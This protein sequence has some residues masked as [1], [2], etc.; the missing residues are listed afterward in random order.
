MLPAIT[1]FSF[2]GRS[3]AGRHVRAL[4]RAL[5][6][7]ALTMLV[8]CGGGSDEPPPPPAQPDNWVSRNWEMSVHHPDGST[9]VVVPNTSSG[10]RP[11]NLQHSFGP[12]A[13]APPG[14][15]FEAIGEVFSNA[16]GDTYWV[17][18]QAPMGDVRVPQSPIGSSVYYNQFQ[19]FRKT[20]DA[21]D[22]DLVISESTLEAMDYNPFNPAN[23]RGCSRETHPDPEGVDITTYEC[24]NLIDAKLTYEVFAW[25]EIPIKDANGNVTGSSQV[26]LTH[27]SVFSH[28]YGYIKGKLSLYPA[29]HFNSGPAGDGNLLFDQQPDFVYSDNVDFNAD[30]THARAFLRQ[31]TVIHI[32]LDLVNRD[33]EFRVVVAVTADTNN[34]RQRES[35]AG[36]FLRDP[37]KLSGVTYRSNGVAPVTVAAGTVGVAGTPPAP[38]PVQAAPACATGVDPAAGVLQFDSDSTVATEASV[39]GMV[40]VWVTRSGGGVGALTVRVATQDDSAHAGADYQAV[41][42]LVRFADGE[43]GQRYVA[44]PLINNSLV[45][46]DRRLTLTLSELR[47]CAVLGP[48]ASTV[49]T[50][51]DDETPPPP[52]SFTLGGTVTGL[53]GSGLSLRNTNGGETV[54]PVADGSFTFASPLA[55]G[56]A[57]AVSVTTQPANPAQTCTVTNGS[58]TVPGANVT[59]IVVA[60][61]SPAPNSSLDAGFGSAG[62]LSNTLPAAKA[63]ALQADGK[64][65]LLGGMTLSRYNADGSTDAGFGTAGRV[66][67]VANGGGL[68]AMQALAVQADGRVVVAGYTALPVVFNQDMVVLRYNADGSLDTTFGSGGKVVTDFTGSTDRA[69][70]VLVQADGKIVAAGIATLGSGTSADQDL[71]LVRYLANGALDTGFGVG[72]KVTTN[73]AGTADFGYAAAL[74]P[75]GKIVVAGRV[76]ANG[77]ANPDFGLARYLPNGTLDA[78]FGSSGIVRIDF[79]GNV[80]D[81]ASDLAVQGDGKIVVGGQAAFGSSYRFAL[82]RLN[83]NGTLDTGFGTAG[84]VRT[85]F[86]TRNDYGRGLALQADG[87]IVLAGQVSGSL[88]ADFGVARYLSSG[89]VDTGFG[90]AGLVQVDFFGATDGAMDVVVQPDGK[91]VAAGSA[92]NGLATGLAIVRVLP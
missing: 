68:D 45:D 86:S 46:P 66:T 56:L 55:D 65:L 83:A 73:I 19:A 84:L 29:W 47:G 64:L 80:W 14:V 33:E 71:A 69:Y 13:I 34:R 32:P 59:N 5:G 74:Q 37:Q 28:L 85:D 58:G 16:A 9:A 51:V 26:D 82:L 81:E 91:I 39:G 70:A 78:G 17:A 27:G 53:Q 63:L 72:G 54:Q 8:S 87:R 36:V 61:T 52:A 43:Q 44:V 2:V 15:P 23:T 18:T 31:S 77:G 7:A 60:C 3:L 89:A 49:V 75:D 35:Y 50:I 1:P 20:T 67:I 57:Y 21:A 76:A 6:L 38:A 4:G 12:L 30:H 90:T 24:G 11:V 62:K 41:S 40:P 42:T 79:G 22:M 25:K 92:R 48:Q 10:N 88:S